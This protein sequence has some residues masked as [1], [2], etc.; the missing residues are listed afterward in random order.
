MF[1]ACPLQLVLASILFAKT[2]LVLVLSA[3]VLVLVIETR[4]AGKNHP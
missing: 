3:A 2:Q 1:A 4:T